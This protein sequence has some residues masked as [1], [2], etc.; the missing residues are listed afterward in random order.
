[1]ETCSACGAV[2]SPDL[3]WCGRCYAPFDRAAPAAAPQPAAPRRMPR[4]PGA[5]AAAPPHEA[6][7]SRW[8]ASSTSFGPVG[9]ALLSLLVLAGVVIGY[10]LVRGLIFS[11]VGLDVPGT[12]FLALY[13]VVAIPAAAYLLSRIWRRVRVA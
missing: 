13:A 3:Q 9:R 8:R 2:R 1:M 5:T 6:E 12:G 7:F 11:L 4:T 10:P